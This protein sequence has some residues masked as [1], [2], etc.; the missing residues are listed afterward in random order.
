MPH[1]VP[2]VYGSCITPRVSG[3]FDESPTKE[4]NKYNG[5]L[6]FATWNTTW[7]E[8]PPCRFTKAPLP[9]AAP[10]A[11]ARFRRATGAPGY[12]LPDELRSFESL[13]ELYDR[14]A[15][16]TIGV[17]ESVHVFSVLPQRTRKVC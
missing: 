12:R 1:T 9:R 4:G 2:L 7:L 16:T 15:M 13:F 8:D 10:H 3:A 14:I 5:N 6:G 11:S 17:I